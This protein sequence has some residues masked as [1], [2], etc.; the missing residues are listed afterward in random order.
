MEFPGVLKSNFLGLLK[1]NVDFPVG[2]QEKIMWNSQGSWL[3]S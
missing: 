2:D 3:R 1:N